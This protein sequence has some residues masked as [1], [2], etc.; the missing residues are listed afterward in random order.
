MCKCKLKLL[1]LRSAEVKPVS[2]DFK[3]LKV[4]SRHNYKDP[5]L[6][7][8]SNV[9]TQEILYRSTLALVSLH[10]IGTTILGWVT[11]PSYSE[12]HGGI[13][14]AI[15]PTWMATTTVD[16]TR[17]SPTA[18]NGTRGPD[19][20]TRWDS[21]RWSSDHDDSGRCDS[22]SGRCDSNTTIVED[23]IRTVEDVIR[24]RRFSTN[25]FQ[26][27]CRLLK[28]MQTVALLVNC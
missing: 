7:N 24:T 25:Y 27:L 26:H 3:I 16:H 2:S 4:S 11:V 20:I 8:V 23:V 1:W 21:Q 19:I 14:I 22:N 12:E 13:K 9:F 17:R 6:L 28:H 18:S 15:Y 5:Y 10:M